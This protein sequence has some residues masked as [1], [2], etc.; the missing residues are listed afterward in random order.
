MSPAS[1][2]R[3]STG[4]NRAARS[5]SRWSAEL[6]RFVGHRARRPRQRQRRVIARLERRQRVERRREGERLPL[7]DRHVADVRRVD[8]LDAAL[9]QRVVD[10]ARDEVVRDVVQDLVLEALLD[11][12]RRRL[13]RPEAGDPRLA[14]VVARRAVDRGVH[15]VAGNLDAHVLARLVDVDEFGFHGWSNT[16]G[17]RRPAFARPGPVRASAG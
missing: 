9:A 5:R 2:P 17:D 15:H 6:D 3:P 16:L 11:D 8:R 10:R 13:A 14:R 12:P 1:T 4:S 7:L